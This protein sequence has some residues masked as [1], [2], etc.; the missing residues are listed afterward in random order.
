MSKA[1]GM[2]GGEKPDVFRLG[3]ERRR[4]LSLAEEESVE[5]GRLHN[6]YYKIDREMTYGMEKNSREC[7]ICVPC[8]CNKD[9]Y[10]L[11]GHSKK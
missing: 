7:D 8:Y 1:L 6:E 9:T 10:C 2:G 11:S 4:Y 5:D 3:L